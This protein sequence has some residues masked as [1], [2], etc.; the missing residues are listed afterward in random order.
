ML[1]NKYDTILK[2]YQRA[3]KPILIQRY[4]GKHQILGDYKL[5]NQSRADNFVLLYLAINL[6]KVIGII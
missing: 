5:I 2:L 4:V 3:I 6:V 1:T